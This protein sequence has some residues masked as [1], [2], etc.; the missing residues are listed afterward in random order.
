MLRRQAG[1]RRKPVRKGRGRAE[2]TQPV[3]QSRVIAPNDVGALAAHRLDPAASEHVLALG[4][5]TVSTASHGP[6]FVNQTASGS[7]IQQR[8]HQRSRH[9]AGVCDAAPRSLR[10]VRGQGIQRGGDRPPLLPADPRRRRQM[11]A[12]LVTSFSAWPVRVSR[13]DLPGANANSVLNLVQRGHGDYSCRR[14]GEWRLSHFRRLSHRS[15]RQ[16]GPSVL[17]GA[18]GSMIDSCGAP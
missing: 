17:R 18:D 7:G 1:L 13:N 11:P 12:T 14:G 9:P 16:K 2:Q 6:R 8:A 5:E 3:F 10:R 15:A 4:V